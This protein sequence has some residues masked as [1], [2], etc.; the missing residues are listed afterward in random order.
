MSNVLV[1]AELADGHVRK[2]THSA[3][4]FAREVSKAGGSFSILVLGANAKAAAAALTGFGAAKVLVAEDASIAHPIAERLAPTVAAVAK[5]GT[6]DVVVATAS[7]FGKDLVPRVAGKLGAGYAGDVS[8]VKVE[9]GK[10]SYKRPIYAGN[11]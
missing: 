1:I 4:T 7:S 6:F 8:A 10:L 5:A 9:G 11:A 2:S 3:V